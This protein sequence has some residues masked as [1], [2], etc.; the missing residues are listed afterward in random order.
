ML[1]RM[2][3]TQVKIQNAIKQHWQMLAMRET[4]YQYI[5]C[6]EQVSN[7][8]HLCLCYYN[9]L[10]SNSNDQN[11]SSLYLDH[12]LHPLAAQRMLSKYSQEHLQK[13]GQ[14]MLRLHYF[15]LVGR[16]VRTSFLFYQ[17]QVKLIFYFARRKSYPRLPVWFSTI[18]FIQTMLPEISIALDQEQT[19]IWSR[20][21]ER[22][23]QIFHTRNATEKCPTC[24]SKHVHLF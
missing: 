6:L 5:C 22:H 10:P 11:C 21:R 1:F 12:A 14:K 18:L 2:E 24:F 7:T 16:A 3:P 9:I 15:T 23:H 13:S 4:Q 8:N 17:L 19:W 20:T